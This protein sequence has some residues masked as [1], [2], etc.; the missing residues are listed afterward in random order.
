MYRFIKN[1]MPGLVLMLSLVIITGAAYADGA[2]SVTNNGYKIWNICS[3][4]TATVTWSG[5][6]D[7]ENY[8]TGK[9]IIQWLEDGELDLSYDGDVSKGKANGKGIMSWP[10][11]D[12]YDGDF[13]DGNMTGKGIFTCIKGDRY[14]GDFV[15][16]RMNGYGTY[17]YSDGTVKQGKWVNDEFI[18]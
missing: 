7:D 9:G 2:W 18:S 15:N 4:P 1:S 8:A 11:G 10:S 14:E 6:A 5:R 12:R 16:G 17:Y 3:E 13:V